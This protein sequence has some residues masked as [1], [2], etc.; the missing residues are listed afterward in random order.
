[1][2]A[3]TNYYRGGSRRWWWNWHRMWKL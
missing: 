1:M 2:I 3:L